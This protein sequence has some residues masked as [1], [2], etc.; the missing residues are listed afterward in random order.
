MCQDLKFYLSK[1]QKVSQIFNNFQ[2]LFFSCFYFWAN[3]Q[4]YFFLVSFLDYLNLLLILIKC[5]I[6]L[7][8]I[9][10]HLRFQKIQNF[11]FQ[12][13]YFIF[14]TL[15][16]SNPSDKFSFKFDL[17]FPL[18]FFRIVLLFIQQVD[19]YNSIH[20][21]FYIFQ[22]CFTIILHLYHINFFLLFLL[23][24][25]FCRLFMKII[26]QNFVLMFNG[27][28]V[29]LFLIHLICLLIFF[30]LSSN[31]SINFALHS[32]YAFLYLRNCLFCFIYILFS[33]LISFVLE[34]IEFC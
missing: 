27:Q 16:D 13:F 22:V 5:S 8:Y 26:F 32:S 33:S 4:Y 2:N 6:L 19:L 25:F 15:C 28:F 17:L 1:L 14:H 21:S 11:F 12:F 23:L 24:L 30:C 3:F 34:V 9:F 10:N 18:K 7:R 29:F 20:M 31:A